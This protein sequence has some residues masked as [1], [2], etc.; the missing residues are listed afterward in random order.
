MIALEREIL[1]GGTDDLTRRGRRAQAACGS[2]GAAAVAEAACASGGAA[3]V[4]EAACASGG[5][6]AVA[7]A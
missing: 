5:A 3:A 6:A 7:E 2:G 1:P 4:A